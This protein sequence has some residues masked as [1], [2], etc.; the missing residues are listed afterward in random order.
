[1]EKESIFELVTRE[2]LDRQLTHRSEKHLIQDQVPKA[3]LA[4]DFIANQIQIN[5]VYEREELIALFEFLGPFKDKFAQGTAL[6]VGANIG[7]HTRYFSDFFS[8]VHAFE[9]VKDTF[10]V[11]QFNTQKISCIDIHN[12]A[13][14]VVDKK[15]R[16]FSSN[17]NIGGA[18]ILREESNDNFSEEVQVK[19]LDTLELDLSALKFMK[20]DVEGF[21]F[22]VLSGALKVITGQHPVITIEQ[23]PSDFT[24]E[25]SPSINLLREIGYEFFWKKNYSTSSSKTISLL[26]KIYQRLTNRRKWYFVNSSFVP[27]GYYPMLVAIHLD[28]LQLLKY[29]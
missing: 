9:P 15:A 27:P 21:E 17:L 7:N 10:Q 6:D 4:H 3:I 18:R 24:N 22:E 1:M 13:L 5:G 14:G 23:W 26:S 29:N 16:I 2:L 12:I 28:D 25:Y 8:K 11:L 19:K 20:I